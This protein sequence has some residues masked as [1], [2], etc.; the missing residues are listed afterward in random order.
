MNRFKH[1]AVCI[2]FLPATAVK[3]WADLQQSAEE[4]KAW[5]LDRA[6]TKVWQK[7]AP[8]WIPVCEN[9]ED[10]HHWHMDHRGQNQQL[11]EN[12]KNEAVIV[13]SSKRRLKNALTQEIPLPLLC[14]AR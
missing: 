9:L 4:T 8:R 6:E 2:A 14:A 12:E 3:G 1:V 11:L 5:Q 10:R 13:E 7:D